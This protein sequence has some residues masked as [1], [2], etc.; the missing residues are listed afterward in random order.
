MTLA[1]SSNVSFAD[2]ATFQSSPVKLVPADEFPFSR[3]HPHFTRRSEYGRDIPQ[4]R[5]TA[6]VTATR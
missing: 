3:N 1:A 5:R 2:L 4:T 6:V